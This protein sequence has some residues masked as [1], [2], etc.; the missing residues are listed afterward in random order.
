MSSCSGL[1]P[2]LAVH[3]ECPPG[4]QQDCS[5]WGTRGWVKQR[6]VVHLTGFAGVR[7]S[8]GGG[9]AQASPSCPN[10]VCA[11]VVDQQ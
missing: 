5:G 7:G 11:G 1:M 2:A 9:L 4:W 10:R 6:P 3:V 8:G